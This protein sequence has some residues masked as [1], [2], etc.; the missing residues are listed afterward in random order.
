MQNPAII[1]LFFIINAYLCITKKD[2]EKHME[3]LDIKEVYSAAFVLKDIIRKTDLI[4]SPLMKK[5][6]DIY[7]KP[8]NLQVTGSFK[9]RGSSYMISQLSAEVKPPIGSRL[10]WRKLM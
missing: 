3:K 10:D 5:G 9:V 8:E 6:C 1:L 2:N 7:I 4:A